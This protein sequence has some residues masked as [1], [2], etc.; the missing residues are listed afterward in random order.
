[1]ARFDHRLA[2]EGRGPRFGVLGV[3]CYVRVVHRD[4]FIN[5]IAWRIALGE[6]LDGVD[7]VRLAYVVG[8]T[9]DGD[10]LLAIGFRVGELLATIRDGRGRG[11][12]VTT[13]AREKKQQN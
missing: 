3:P 12:V 5:T 11:E 6:N 10:M 8:V 4:D 7:A 9:P 2:N 13:T 1:L